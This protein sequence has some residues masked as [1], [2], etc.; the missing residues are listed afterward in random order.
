M[1]NRRLI[2][3]ISSAAL[4]ICEAALATEEWVSIDTME[5]KQLFLAAQ[6]AYER[7]DC[8][9][10]NRLLGIYL[11]KAKPT[12]R[13]RERILNVIGWCSVYLDKGSERHTFS[14]CC[15]PNFTPEERYIENEFGLSMNRYKKPL[16]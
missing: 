13:Q 5:P 15:D 16:K 10:T 6:V 11:T 14:G 12:N 4:L 7:N 3:M 8:S 9:A 2:L 1:K